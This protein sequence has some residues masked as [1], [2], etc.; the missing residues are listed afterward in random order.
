[1]KMAGETCSTI[2][3]SPSVLMEYLTL[4]S[5]KGAVLSVLVLLRSFFFFSQIVH[6]ADHSLF[7]DIFVFC[8]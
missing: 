2:Q 8:V 5:A 1:M 4:H 6:P 3:I 7:I